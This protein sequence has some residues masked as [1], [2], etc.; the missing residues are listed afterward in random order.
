MRREVQIMRLAGG[1]VANSRRHEKRRKAGESW[2]N[3][4]NGEHVT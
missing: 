4:E 3:S 2:E 1:E